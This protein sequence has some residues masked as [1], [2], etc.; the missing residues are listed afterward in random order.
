MA[1]P[2]AKPFG[3]GRC[4]LHDRDIE[5]EV[6]ARSDCTNRTTADVA[7]VADG[8]AEYDTY[9]GGGW[10]EVGGTS[11]ATPMIAGIYALAGNAKSQHAGKE[12]WSLKANKR[13]NSLHYISSGSDG[14]CGGSYLCTAGT[15]QFETYGGPIGWGTPNGLGAF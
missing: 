6:A 5:A 7:A 3:R 13:K 8:V 9:E 1:R 10:F 4:G 2:I 14:S 12:L 11:V 15:K